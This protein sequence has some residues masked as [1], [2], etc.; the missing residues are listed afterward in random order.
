MAK[1]SSVPGIFGGEDFYDESGRKVGYS[2]PG[3]FG[4]RDFYDADI[5]L[6]TVMVAFGFG[7]RRCGMKP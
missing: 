5:V 7:L 6:S 1:I 4:G 3:I 2:V